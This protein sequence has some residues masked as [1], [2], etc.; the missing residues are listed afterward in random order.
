MSTGPSLAEPGLCKFLSAEYTSKTG[1]VTQQYDRILTRFNYFLTIES[2][3]IGVVGFMLQ[4]E[5]Y[6]VV[7]SAAR[8]A[9]R[10]CPS[11]HRSARR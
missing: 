8:S 6:S 2:G 5:L 3:L 9:S 7:Y 1:L 11:G 10:G 4:Q